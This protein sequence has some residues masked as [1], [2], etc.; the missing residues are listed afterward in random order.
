MVMVSTRI[1][2][3]KGKDK[4]KGKAVARARQCVKRHGRK[5]TY[6][7]YAH[8]ARPIDTSIIIM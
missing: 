8:P 5:C 4:D 6:N 2:N 1:S 7:V 3:G